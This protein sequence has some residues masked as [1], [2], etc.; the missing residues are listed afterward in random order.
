MNVH[1]FPLQRGT[2]HLH[3]LVYCCMSYA[4]YLIVLILEISVL[5]VFKIKK[6]WSFNT[7]YVYDNTYLYHCNTVRI[8]GTCIFTISIRQYW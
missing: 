2:E 6:L 3:V 4:V 7:T 5:C 8:S 1:S